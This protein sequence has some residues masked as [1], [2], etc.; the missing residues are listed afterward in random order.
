MIRCSLQDCPEFDSHDLEVDGKI[1]RITEGIWHN[2]YQFWIRGRSL[3]ESQT[4]QAYILRLLDQSEDWQQGPEPRDR[5]I[6]EATTLQVLRKKTVFAHLTPHFICFVR[7]DES[8]P[9]GMIETALPGHSLQGNKDQSIL[10]LVGQVAADVHR[11]DINSFP[12]LPNSGSRAEH[13]R[14]RLAELDKAM[15]GAFPMANEVREWIMANVPSEDCSCL[16]HG[17]LLPQNLLCEWPRTDQQEPRLGVI[18]WEM[19][20]VGDPAY[21]LAIVSRGDRKLLGVKDGL[22]VLLELYSDCG[23]QSISLTDV[24]LHELLLLL[25]WLEESWREYH[26]PAPGGHAPEY[27]EAKLLSLFRR[28]AS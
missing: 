19:A 24:R 13:L 2:N 16:L 12:H 27:Y 8:E 3:S 21:D 11:L 26:S 14:S 7:N 18:D 4:D 5:L 28:T 9:I 20:Q 1:N 25:H 22:K 17:D 10:R 23:G 6:R 15:F